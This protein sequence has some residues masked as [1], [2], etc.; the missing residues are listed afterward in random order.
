MEIGSPAFDDQERIPR[1]HTCDGE[2]ISPALVIEGVPDEAVEL[3]LVVDDPDAPGGTFVHW[4]VWGMPA[5]GGQIPEGASGSGDFREG[6]NGF[7]RRGWGGP[8]PPDGLHHYRFRVYALDRAPELPDGA[9][10]EELGEALDGHVVA[11]ARL[12]G[13][14][15]R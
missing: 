6:E 14:Y 1:R 2:D 15:P 5:D 7:G 11:E 12:V 13:T 4:V 9:G 10:A 3:A 8:C